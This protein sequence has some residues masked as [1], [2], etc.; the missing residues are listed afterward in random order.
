MLRCL[1][2]FLFIGFLLFHC[3]DVFDVF[4]LLLLLLFLF[5]FFFSLVIV[6]SVFFFPFVCP[7]YFLSCKYFYICTVYFVVVCLFVS[8]V[9]LFVCCRDVFFSFVFFYLRS[10]LP[11]F[12]A[13]I[14]FFYFSY[15][16]FFS[17]SSP[18]TNTNNTSSSTPFLSSSSYHTPAPSAINTGVCR[19]IRYTT[20][21]TTTTTHDPVS[22]VWPRQKEIISG[23]WIMHRWRLAIPSKRINFFISLQKFWLCMSVCEAFK[24][25]KDAA[26]QV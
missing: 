3:C 6:V 16:S 1:C 23:S 26:L 10:C 9:C 22:S 24:L 11:S 25:L 4:Y 7:F 8:S 19:I 21:T 20:T 14:L 17:F 18:F 2:F 12:V 15:F 13:S 5:F